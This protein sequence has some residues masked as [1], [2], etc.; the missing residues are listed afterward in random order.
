MS[1]PF[2]ERWFANHFINRIGHKTA[3]ALA[4][5]LCMLWS[6]SAALRAPAETMPAAVA[7]HEWPS[8]WDGVAL[9]PLALSDVEQRFADRFPGAIGRM[10]DGTQ[11]LVMREVNQPTRMLHPATDCYRA[12]GYRIEQARLERDA[13]E[14]M[15]RCFVAQRHGAQKIR[16][17]ERI[18]DAQGTAFTDTS[19]WYWAAASGQSHGPWQAVTV[20]RPI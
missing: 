15:W 10:T 2:F 16:V 12:L 17:C 14:R 4:M 18:V 19:S 7:S 20:A 11:T 9:R 1:T 6:A 5:L 3:F 13:Q 8:Q